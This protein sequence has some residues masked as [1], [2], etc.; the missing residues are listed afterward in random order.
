[1]DT[2]TITGLGLMTA[3]VVV[4]Q[5]ISNYVQIGPVSI[6]LAIIPIVIG[7]IIYGPLCG[8]L[9]GM[10]DGALILSAPSTAFFLGY[11]VWATVFLCLMKTGIAGLVSGFIPKI[12][13][14]DKVA[15]VVC[16]VL[17][18][19]I[20][21][22]LFVLGCLAFFMP[23]LSETLGVMHVGDILVILVGVNFFIEF[24]VLVVLSPTIYYIYKIIKKKY[25]QKKELE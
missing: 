5:L 2:K 7:S 12:I 13:K 18:P 23:L 6:N 8:L 1:M 4:L 17:V 24:G 22:G 19:I 15:V 3:L 9:L 16:S 20:N 21:T 25:L 10:V 14:N 11:N